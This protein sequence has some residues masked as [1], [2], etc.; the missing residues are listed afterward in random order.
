M[1]EYILQNEDSARVLNSE[2]IEL[3]CDRRTM[4]FFEIGQLEAVGRVLELPAAGG[5]VTALRFQGP[6]SLMGRRY[7]VLIPQTHPDYPAL[8]AALR[9]TAPPEPYRKRVCDHTGPRRHEA[10]HSG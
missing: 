7:A 8:C 5:P 3:F 2:A 9:P 6:D 1:E 4:I 10:P